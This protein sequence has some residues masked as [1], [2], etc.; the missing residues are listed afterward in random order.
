MFRVDRALSVPPVPSRR[1]VRDLAR[2]PMHPRLFLQRQKTIARSRELSVHMTIVRLA[3]SVR[4][5][6]A[7]PRTAPHERVSDPPPHGH[8]LDVLLRDRARGVQASGR[9]LADLRRDGLLPLALH[10][11]GQPQP[12]RWPRVLLRPSANA[13][14][15]VHA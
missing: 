2:V 9:L 4:G 10:R 14:Q 11:D 7:Q 3:R 6:H 13:V 12:A 1:T 15:T 8:L 5:R